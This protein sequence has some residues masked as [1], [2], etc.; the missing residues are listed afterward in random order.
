M[1]SA[2]QLEGTRVRTGEVLFRGYCFYTLYLLRFHRPVAAERVRWE[3]EDMGE[4]K[5]E[6]ILK[7]L[8]SVRRVRM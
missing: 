2:I 7:I 8:F 4:I 6:M 5:M 3:R 1:I